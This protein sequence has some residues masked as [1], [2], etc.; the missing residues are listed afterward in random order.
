MEKLVEIFKLCL[1][2]DYFP[3]TIQFFQVVCTANKVRETEKY[4]L[5][6]KQRMNI[7]CSSNGFLLN[8]FDVMLS[9]SNK[10]SSRTDNTFEKIDKNFWLTVPFEGETMLISI[11]TVYSRF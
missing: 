4:S 10:I 3:K 9:L 5:M 6:L 1:I 8:I 2:K 11:D 7:N